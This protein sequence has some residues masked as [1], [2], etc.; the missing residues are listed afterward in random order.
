M[1]DWIAFAIIAIGTFACWYH[2]V[3]YKRYNP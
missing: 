1:I 3:I 2:C